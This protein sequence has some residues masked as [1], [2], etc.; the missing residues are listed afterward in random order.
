VVAEVLP[1]G[2]AGTNAL[3]ARVYRHRSGPY[4]LDLGSDGPRP[5][6]A[7]GV[8]A[9]GKDPPLLCYGGGTRLGPGG[10]RPG[11]HLVD[12]RWVP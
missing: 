6:H 5:G 4:G 7:S 10:S 11:D 8:F 1:D 12:P 3:A 2:T 9:G